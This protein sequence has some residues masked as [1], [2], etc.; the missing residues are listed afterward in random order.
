[1]SESLSREATELAEESGRKLRRWL[2]LF[3]R[4]LAEAEQRGDPCDLKDFAVFTA[5]LE[6]LLKIGKL[7]SAARKENA[8][9]DGLPAVDIDA[10]RSL[11]AEED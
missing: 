4:K 5:A 6:R 3:E 9:H 8:P 7:A 2:I 1:M 11:L 10:I